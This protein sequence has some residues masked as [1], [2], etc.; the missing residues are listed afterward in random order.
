MIGAAISSSGSPSDRAA[1]PPGTGAP[2]LGVPIPCGHRRHYDV[3][4]TLSTRTLCGPS[5]RAETR[6]MLSTAAFTPVRDVAGEGDEAG[7]AGDV[8]YRAAFAEWIID[9]EVYLVTS[10]VPRALLM[11]TTLSKTAMSVSIGVAISPP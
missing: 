4:F 10:K 3:G 8:S 2:I 5:S 1:S 9:R 6:V 11:L 7:L